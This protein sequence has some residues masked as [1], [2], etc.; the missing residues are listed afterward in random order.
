M[1]ELRLPG[2]EGVIAWFGS[3]PNFHDA[4]IVSLSLSRTGDSV[5]RVYPYYP[6]KPATVDF[7]L[8]T[9]TDL[10]LA[11]FSVQNV[12][13]SLSAEAVTDQNKEPSIRIILGPCY[14]LSG[15]ID[16]KRVRVEVVP[17][18]APDGKSQW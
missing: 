3:W 1:S 17:G 6:A 14:G 2:E 15:W 11:D 16:S 10:E 12:I 4:E 8:E 9:V 7:I 5:L 13:S 18:K